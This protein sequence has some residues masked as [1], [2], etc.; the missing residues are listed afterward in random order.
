MQVSCRF[1]V[2][3]VGGDGVAVWSLCQFGPASLNPMHQ[4]QYNNTSH[5]K[6]VYTKIEINRVN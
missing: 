4:L 1:V 2:G 5:P 6:S 3:G